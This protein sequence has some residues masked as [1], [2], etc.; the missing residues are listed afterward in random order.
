MW[1]ERQP[2]PVRVHVLWWFH[3]PLPAAHPRSRPI[4]SDL[5]CSAVRP[6][7][8][9]CHSLTMISWWSKCNK[10]LLSPI[11][12]RLIE[13]QYNTTEMAGNLWPNHWPAAISFLSA[14]SLCMHVTRVLSKVLPRTWQRHPAA[15]ELELL[16]VLLTCLQLLRP[17]HRFYEGSYSPITKERLLFYHER[18]FLILK[19]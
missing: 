8:Q 6:R 15:F 17:W 4:R 3:W 19:G 13:V 18:R 5:L 14:G 12:E 9:R 7:N 16:A 1:A 10:F 11:I 2:D